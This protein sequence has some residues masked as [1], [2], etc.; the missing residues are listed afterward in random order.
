MSD[1]DIL[2]AIDGGNDAVITGDQQ[3]GEP[4]AA[5]PD[6]GAA[7]DGSAPPVDA[8]ADPAQQDPAS[9]AATR[10]SQ[11][12]AGTK[13]GASANS[14]SSQND[15]VKALNDYKAQMGREQSTLK[16]ELDELRS[17]QAQARAKEREQHEQS[18]K[19]KL[20]RWDTQHPEHGNFRSV[21]AKRD[22]LSQQIRNID[23]RADLAPEVKEALKQEL[24]DASLSRE[25]QSELSDHW[26]M[27]QEFLTNPVGA[28]REVARNEAQQL[29]AQAFQQF[30]QWNQANSQVG[31]DLTGLPD[32]AKPIL[33]ELLQSGQPYDVSLRLAKAEA[34][35]ASLRG[36]QTG[37]QKQAAHVSE[38]ARLAKSNAT[39]TRDPKPV[40][41]TPS[42]VYN[43]A[44]K[45]GL[46]D[47]IGPAHP[48]FPKL[49]LAVERELSQA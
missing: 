46:V 6:N 23:K 30:N 12:P 35:L 48:K 20:K 28:A 47:G 4:V 18:E 9:E 17:F 45:R 42:A 29:I 36:N 15:P 14:I 32:G 5:A 16:R 3:G 8:P 44:K 24:T 49:L 33:A 43:E 7:A 11:A 41:V 38:Q 1:E 19:L 26:K 10:R 34:E 13:P 2:N 31:T 39:M 40:D 37:V 27:S 21:L 25:E 22:A